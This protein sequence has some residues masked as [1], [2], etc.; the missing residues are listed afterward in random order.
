MWYQKI[1]NNKKKY[2]IFDRRFNPK[3]Y[4]QTYF[5]LVGEAGRLKCPTIA[6]T[7][8][9][10]PRLVQN[11]PV[12]DTNAGKQQFNSLNK[13][14]WGLNTQL[15]KLTRHHRR[16]SNRRNTS[17]RRQITSRAAIDWLAINLTSHV[18]NTCTF[19]MLKLISL[20]TKFKGELTRFTIIIN[21][22]E[23]GD[24]TM[25]MILYREIRTKTN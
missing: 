12:T 3:N 5:L 25:V 23:S 6:K 24:D 15:E 9:P 10:T 2:Y 8:R 20:A 18:F 16:D 1:F 11:D 21:S 13:G 7:Q 19:T 14:A 4:T 17:N 22:R